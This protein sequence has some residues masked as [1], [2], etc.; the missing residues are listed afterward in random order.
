MIGFADLFMGHLIGDYFLQPDWMALN[1]KKSTAICSLHCIIYTLVVWAFTSF[2][3]PVWTLPIIF[4]S[5][6][7]F[8]RSYLVK[9]YCNAMGMKRFLEEPMFPWSWII[10]DNGFHLVVLYALLKILS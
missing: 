4:V 5:H 3:W 10:I 9:T 1:K 6:F 8:D 2:S 7:V